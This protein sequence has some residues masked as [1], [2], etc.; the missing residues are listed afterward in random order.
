MSG[1]KTCNCVDVPR[2]NGVKAHVRNVGACKYALVRS[3][4]SVAYIYI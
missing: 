2:F 4:D 3:V 1:P